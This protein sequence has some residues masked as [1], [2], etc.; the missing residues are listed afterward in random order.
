MGAKAAELLLRQLRHPGCP[1]Q[2]I[3]LRPRLRIRD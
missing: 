2:Q 1:P 3:L